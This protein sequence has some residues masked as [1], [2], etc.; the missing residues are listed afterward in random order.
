MTKNQ[1]NNIH[2][3]VKLTNANL[4]QLVL[5]N[6]QIS[7]LRLVS[8]LKNLNHLRASSNQIF[9]VQPLSSLPKLNYLDIQ[10][11]PIENKTCPV[12]RKY[13]CRF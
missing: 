8:D 13:G 11:N 1:I 4:N 6:N 5:D 3:T 10:N 9:S 2:S 12:Q 7:D